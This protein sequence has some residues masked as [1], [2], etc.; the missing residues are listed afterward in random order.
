M[1]VLE[2]ITLTRRGWR[3]LLIAMVV[4]VIISAGYV[5]VAP[6][7]YASSSNGFIATDGSAVIA[8][9]DQATQLVSSYLPLI[10]S[11]QVY[12]RI[13][14]SEGAST[15]DLSGALSAT[16]VS[17]STMIQVTATASTPEAAAH[18]ANGA[19]N[20]L[21]DVISKV[22]RAAGSGGSSLKVVPLGNAEVPSEPSSPRWK[23]VIPLG[24]LAGIVVGYAILLMRG[25][26]DVRVRASTD[27]NELIGAG[28][29][30]RVPRLGARR[31]GQRTEL[32]TLA[33]ESFRQ[34]RTSLRFA[35]VDAEVR[36]IAVTSAN[37]SE[38]KS[39]T[40]ARLAQVLAA[41]GQRV[42]LIDADL[43]R[44]AVARMFEVDG[45]VGLSEV[46]S[47]QVPLT[48]AI[49]QTKNQNLLVLPAGGIP[50]NPSEMLGANA[51]RKLL[52]ELRGEC[53]II[54][55]TP[56]V[57]PVTDALL[58]GSVTDGVVFVVAVG[59]TRKAEVAAAR[60]LLEPAR[61]R[62]LGAV[63]NK[64]QISDSDGGYQYYR[65]SYYSRT[66]AGGRKDRRKSKDRGA[67]QQAVPVAN[68]PGSEPTASTSRRQS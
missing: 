65:Y 12:E 51:L 53:I 28:V 22:E 1:T 50:P 11:A 15:S 47:G 37:Q 62:L 21:A 42:L 31:K 58:V 13:A 38:G 60:K 40:A 25:A 14:K 35:S 56:P 5:L 67:L 4:G 16:L 45:S 48:D 33:D 49:R 8:G 20:A 9:S 43:R 44:P 57:L 64:V 29:L 19:L 54:V 34:I 41:T 3:L 59:Q 61:V 17:G 24:A 52:D 10:T 26:I 66:T 30:G 63:M 6:K 55:D 68:V 36:T 7:S 23:I 18:L 2:L 27:M 46:L 39:T 32:E